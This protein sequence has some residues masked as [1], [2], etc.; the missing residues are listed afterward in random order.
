MQ[1]YILKYKLFNKKHCV[2]LHL[3]SFKFEF[4]TT[5]ILINVS[6]FYLK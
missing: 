3:C 5:I 4:Y 1:F 2:H 6:V